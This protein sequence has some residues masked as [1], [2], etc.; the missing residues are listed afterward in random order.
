MILVFICNF[1]YIIYL[2]YSSYILLICLLYTLIR[3]LSRMKQ[4][5]RP[6]TEVVRSRAYRKYRINPT[7]RAEMPI[8]R[9]TA[10]INNTKTWTNPFVLRRDFILLFRRDSSRIK[11]PKR[12][13]VSLLIANPL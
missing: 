8:I 5:E 6:P 2:V 13:R 10:S 3:F 4:K 11:P 12:I 1:Y 7:V 9:T